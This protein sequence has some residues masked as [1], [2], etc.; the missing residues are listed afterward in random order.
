MVLSML[1][2]GTES[3]SQICT[4]NCEQ[5]PVFFGQWPRPVDHGPDF[6]STGT[7]MT[8]TMTRKRKGQYY[9]D[10]IWPHAVREGPLAMRLARLSAMCLK[11]STR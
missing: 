5:T 3:A 9:A 11:T 2:F 10:Q 7:L 8:R 6:E 1:A 4:A